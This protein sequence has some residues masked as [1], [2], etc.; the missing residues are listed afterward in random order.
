MSRFQGQQIGYVVGT[1]RNSRSVVCRIPHS[2][3]PRAPRLGDLVQLVDE[4]DR[5]SWLGRIEDEKHVS[6]DL[7]EDEIRNSIARGMY[8]KQE[9]SEREKEMYLGHDFAILVLGE[10]QGNS[11]D[12]FRPIVRNLPPRGTAVKQLER[13]Q[14]ASLVMLDKEGPIVGHYAVG[15]EVFDTGQD[16]LPI[17]FSIERFVSRRTAIFGV[18]GFGK[19]NLM[20]DILAYVAVGAPNV[21]KLV[22]DLDGEYAFGTEQ[23]IGL[24]DIDKVKETLLVFTN[25]GR[26]DAKYQDVI[27]GPAS[28]NLEH[29][30]P[31]RAVTLLLPESRRDRVYAGILG[32]LSKDKWISIVRYIAENRMASDPEEV[33]KLLGIELDKNLASITGIIN[34]L[35]PM[36]RGHTTESTLLTE[37]YDALRAGATVIVDLSQMDLV[38][39]FNL[40]LLLVED[41]FDNNRDA[42]VSGGEVPKIIVFAE[43]AQNLL[44]E[45]QVREG[46]SIVRLA[47]EGRKYNLGLTYVTQQPGAIAGEILSQT[48]NFFVLHL[49]AKGDIK[50]LTDVNPHYDGVISQFIQSESL[51]G[52]AYIYSTV[53]G[54]PIQSYTFGTKAVRFA[55][56][57]D[58]LSK[59]MP[60]GYRPYRQKR[61]Q[62]TEQI[63]NE[64]RNILDEPLVPQILAGYDEF[65]VFSW[66]DISKK[67]HQKL[68]AEMNIRQSKYPDQIED[69]WIAQGFAHLGISYDGWEWVNKRPYVLI[70]KSQSDGSSVTEEEDIPF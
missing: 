19:S 14:L 32:S 27:A 23:G 20:K 6:I 25:S 57:K 2:D 24:A 54:L 16:A 5:R 38:S 44:S 66:W 69:G 42:F 12:E 22:F 4:A 34:A 59:I 11:R 17:R 50:A 1:G 70:P 18:A 26:I 52:H 55:D 68:P 53:P 15:D 31:Y 61:L 28:I 40:M 60:K 8:L 39:A 35:V 41:L 37:A 13:Q 21:G 51:Q 56:V 49:L 29:L 33:A 62:W 45:R 36:L 64:L 67:L 47:K 46:N 10:L 3:M 63:A 65:D 30:S 9:L 43:E 48:N 7:K 58:E